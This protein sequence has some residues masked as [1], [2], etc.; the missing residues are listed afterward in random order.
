MECLTDI[1]IQEYV[2]NELNSVESAIARD[3]LIVCASCKAQYTRYQQLEKLLCQPVELAP[4]NI[5]EL[6]V[7]NRLFP[8]I[9]SYTSIL[10]LIAASFVLLVT[11]I[12][13]YF[14]FANNSIIQALQLTSKN[15]SN[16]IA[17]IITFIS[18]VFSSVYAVFKVLNR[19]I[20]IVFQINLGAE[21]VGLALLLMVSLLFYTLFKA[22]LKRIKN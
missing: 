16:W 12:Y 8:K 6:H 3:H 17:S 9:P 14:D 15:T 5:I 22:A 1:K 18:T 11:G 10:A 20:A 13:I 2:D 21:I 4:P 7:M 19:F